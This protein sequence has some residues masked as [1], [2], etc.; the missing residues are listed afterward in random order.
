MIV[1]VTSLMISACK[2]GKDRRILVGLLTVSLSDG[3]RGEM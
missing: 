1:S 3:R 2:G